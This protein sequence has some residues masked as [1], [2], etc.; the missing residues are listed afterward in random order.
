MKMK[1]TALIGLVVV[2]LLFGIQPSQAVT[3]AQGQQLDLEGTLNGAPY[4]IRVPAQWNGIL[5]VFAHGYRDKADHPGETDNRTAEAAPGGTP[6]ENVLLSRGYAVAGSAFLDNGWAVKEGI[7]D[8]LALT[9]FFKGRVGEPRHTIL[10]GASMGSV[11]VFKSIED[12]PNVYDG[13]IPACG[14]GAGTPRN[15]DVGL[16]DALAYDVTFGWPAMWGTPGDVRDD[17]DFETEVLPILRSQV[18]DRANFGRFEFIRLVTRGPADGFYSGPNW[19]FTDFFFVTE[20]RAEL[21]RRAGG[22]VVQNLNHEYTLTNQEKTYLASLGVNADAL[23]ATMNARRNIAASRSARRYLENFADYTG[24][25]NRPVLSIHTTV[26]GLVLT[27]NESAY[28]ATVEAAGKQDN[29]LQ[30]YTNSVGH[31][32]FRPEQLLAAVEAMKAWV[33]GGLRPNLQAFPETL[34]FVPSFMPPPWPQP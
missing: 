2:L 24:N 14:L 32:T 16:D 25:I 19:L 29:L 30:V 34:G 4:K 28:R 13:A 7:A 17:L 20:A 3:P 27:A 22:P 12:Y 11:V 6:F 8:T 23:L 31:C 10:W 33:E 26:D 21:E 1:K 15:F 5:L 18:S 9:S